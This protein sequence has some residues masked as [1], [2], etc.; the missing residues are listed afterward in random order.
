MI[1]LLAVPGR[2]GIFRLLPDRELPLH[3]LSERPTS[4]SHIR[5]LYFPASAAILLSHDKGDVRYC[6]RTLGENTSHAVMQV[7]TS[8]AHQFTRLKIKPA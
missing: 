3:V 4:L 5:E 7:S 6:C 1:E 2:S 8:T